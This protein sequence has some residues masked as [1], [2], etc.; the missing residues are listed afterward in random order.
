MT[1]TSDSL[2][3]VLLLKIGETKTRQV[4]EPYSSTTGS[5]QQH[6]LLTAPLL[7]ALPSTQSKSK[8]AQV[9]GLHTAPVQHTSCSGNCAW[10]AGSP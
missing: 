3:C 9:S 7:P 6:V 1:G 2:A 10:K 4:L 5:G 8:A